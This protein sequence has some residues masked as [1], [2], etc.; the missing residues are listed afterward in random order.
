MIEKWLDFIVD[1]RTNKPHEFDIVEGPMANDQVWN[2]VADFIDGIL[3]REQ[4]WALAKFTPTH[5]LAFCTKR[6]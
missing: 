3:T 5:Q 4:F 1:C 6:A 2:Y